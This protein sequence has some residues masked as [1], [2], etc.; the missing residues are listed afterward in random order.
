MNLSEL[1]SKLDFYVDAIYQKG[2]DCGF[3]TVIEELDA[4]SDRLWNDGHKDAAEV[5][6][7]VVKLVKG[8]FDEE[9]L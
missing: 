7:G 6:R 9:T 3:E 8:T 2:Y 1:K 5:I 4:I